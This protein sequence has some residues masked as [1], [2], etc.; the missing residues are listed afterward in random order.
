LV[1]VLTLAAA[2]IVF[3]NGRVQTERRT[4]PAFTSISV[5]GSGTLRVH[6]GGQRVEIVADSNVLP[7]I[8][9]TVSGGELKIGFKPFTSIT[10]AAKMQFDITLPNLASISVSGSGD[11]YVDAFRGES[12]AGVVSG[13]GGIKADLDYK[14][15]SLH[16][17]GSG[18]FDAAVKAQRLDLRC[19]G[20]GDAFLKGS[21]SNAEIAITGSGTLGARTLAVDEAR[22]VI[23]GSGK[24]EIRAAKS[25]DMVISGSGDVR[26]WGNPSVSQR[27]SGSGRVSKAG[28]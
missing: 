13:S 16:C 27:T 8:T 9:T 7:Y 14:A 5:A 10:N 4:V 12:F 24:A 11:A 18:G 20:S 6:R 2:D 23:S 3:G 15:V 26:Y 21:V 17:S 28:D 22:I 25:L 1:G 19:T